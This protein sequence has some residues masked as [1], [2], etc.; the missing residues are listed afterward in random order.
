MLYTDGLQWQSKTSLFDDVVRNPAVGV[1]W[2]LW[3]VGD[4]ADSGI[5]LLYFLFTVTFPAALATIALGVVSLVRRRRRRRRRR[6]VPGA[7]ALT[8]GVLIWFLYGFLES[9]VF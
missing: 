4:G 7:I 1:F 3:A 5:G 2:A 6:R 9:Q 8:S